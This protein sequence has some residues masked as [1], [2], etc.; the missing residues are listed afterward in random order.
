M[1]RIGL[2]PRLAQPRRRLCASL[3]FSDLPGLVVEQDFLSQEQHEDI[4]SEVRRASEMAQEMAGLSELP[5]MVSPAHNIP[6]RSEYVPVQ[7]PLE[8]Q[9]GP[10][11]QTPNDTTRSAEH[12]CHYGQGHRLTYYRGNDNIPRLGLPRN[13]L[14]R[15]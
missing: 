14:D 10:S 9:L 7:L 6:S 2:C 5:A 1:R 15:L 3:T 8:A 4:F 12:F 13:F 11:S